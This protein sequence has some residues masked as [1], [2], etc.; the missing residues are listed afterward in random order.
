[1]YESMQKESKLALELKNSSSKIASK[2][3][4]FATRFTI[5]SILP[6]NLAI[7]LF[8]FIALT[9]TLAMWKVLNK[10]LLKLLDIVIG[11]LSLN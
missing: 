7:L 10:L 9:S 5:I 6:I 4:W 11:K 3:N 8:S 1:M 2:Y